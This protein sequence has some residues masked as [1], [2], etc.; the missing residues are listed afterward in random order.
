MKYSHC[1]VEEGGYHERERMFEKHIDSMVFPITYRIEGD[2]LKLGNMSNKSK[3]FAIPLKHVPL[4]LE[5]LDEFAASGEKS[6]FTDIFADIVYKRTTTNILVESTN[7]G[8]LSIPI[9][10]VSKFAKEAFTILG[11]WTR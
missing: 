3:Y 8:N 10:K 2:T 9:I 1:G 11:Q 6:K 5:E 7:Q 4:F